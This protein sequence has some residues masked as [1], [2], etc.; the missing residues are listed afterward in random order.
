MKK[1]II[2]TLILLLISSL[3]VYAAPQHSIAKNRQ[4]KIEAPKLAVGIPREGQTVVGNSMTVQVSSSNTKIKISSNKNRVKEGFLKVWIDNAKP[5]KQ[6]MTTF[7]VNIATLTEGAHVLNIELVK[8]EGK[9]FSTKVLRTVN[10]GVTR[11]A[12]K[13]GNQPRVS[14][15]IHPARLFSNARI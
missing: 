3:V 14:R 4:Q 13:G 7:R 15:L 9:S 1:L 6:Y 8:N 2:L 11:S 12:L 10:F 5:A